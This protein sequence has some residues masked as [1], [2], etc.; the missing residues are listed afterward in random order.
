MALPTDNDPDQVVPSKGPAREFAAFC[1]MDRAHRRN[2]DP[3]FNAE[4]Y[5][6]AVALVLDRLTAFKK[7]VRA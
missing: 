6:E 3:Q 4:L 2:A 7:D 1:E 5:D